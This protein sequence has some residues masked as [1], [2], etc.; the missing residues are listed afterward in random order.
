MKSINTLSITMLVF[1]LLAQPVF[2]EI[3]NTPSEYKIVPEQSTIRIITDKRGL[4]AAAAHQHVVSIKNLSG[5]VVF[6]GESTGSAKMII[7]PE[8]F[9]VDDAQERSLYPDIFTKPV[10]DKA[11]RGTRKNMLGKKLLNAKMF[12]EIGVLLDLAS[13]Q[14]TEAMFN[15]EI[16][17]QD[18][19]IALTLPGSLKI[20]KNALH[21]NA[22][23]KLSNNDLGLKVFSALFGSISVGHELQFHVDLVAKR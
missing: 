18:R 15:V 9:L 4:A 7:Y 6:D 1:A 8:R 21:A 22:S 17:I 13:L 5:S 23:F 10:P 19:K 16:T 2:A 11:I 14:G 12:P 20:E 3:E